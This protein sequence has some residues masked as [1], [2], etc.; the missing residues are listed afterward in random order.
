KDFCEARG[1]QA[2]VVSVWANGG[3]GATEFA[4]KLR[5]MLDEGKD[6]VQP[7]FTADTGVRE[8][9]EHIVTKIYGGEGVDL[10][11]TAEKQLQQLEEA[12]EAK[13]PVGMA[14]TQYSFSDD[15]KTLGAQE[16]FCVT[17]RV[18]SVRAGGG[19]VIP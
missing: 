11:S 4:K 9:I 2:E 18:L 8:H 14:K 13:V 7:M 10:S 17:V 12:G 6:P 1:A 16:G 19:F 3:E 15:P 5:D